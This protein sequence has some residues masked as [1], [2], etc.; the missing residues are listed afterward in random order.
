MSISYQIVAGKNYQPILDEIYKEEALTN[1][2]DGNPELVKE[3]QNP[4][5]L[6]I[7]KIQLSGQAAYNRST[8]YVGGNVNLTWE[9]I[10]A[11][12]DRGRKFNIDDV[13]NMDSFNV[14]LGNIARVYVKEKVGPEI[15]A[16]RIAKY[17][18][19]SGIGGTTGTLSSGADVVAAL[20]TALTTMDEAEV[21]K[22]DRVLLITPTLL[23]MVEDLDTTKSKAVL[24]GFVAVQKVPQTRMYT[25]IDLYDG[26][27]EG[28]ED[29]GYV[30]DPTSGKDIN[31]MVVSRSAVLQFPKHVKPKLVSPE[32]NND[33][34]AWIFGYRLNAVQRVL[35]NKLAGVYCHHKA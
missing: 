11:D 13:D 15:D 33:A 34:D 17:A 22:N 14:A 1:V 28:E 19:T 4:G 9:T 5:E 31:F 24:D 26:T 30:K 10:A 32:A 29:G 35:D 2:L 18:G 3:G 6:V 27:T 20:R 12:Y 25:A 8:G 16:V 23:G 7:G 21:D